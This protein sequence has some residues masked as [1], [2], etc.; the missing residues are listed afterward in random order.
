VSTFTRNMTGTAVKLLLILFGVSL[1]VAVF[2]P[3]SRVIL[4]AL[5]ALVLLWVGVVCFQTRMPLK[6]YLREACD[7]A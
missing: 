6:R 4:I 2:L 7:D 1:L 5:N 3:Q